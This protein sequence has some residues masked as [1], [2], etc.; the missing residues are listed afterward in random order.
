MEIF[1]VILVIVLIVVVGNWLI[2]LRT[3]K[4]P[5]VPDSVKPKPYK[6]DDDEDDW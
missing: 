3:A 4:K 1:W 5:K 6:E 2:L